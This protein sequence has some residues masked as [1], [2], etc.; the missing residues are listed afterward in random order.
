[1]KEDLNDLIKILERA[2]EALYNEEY[3][4]T[5]TLIYDAECVARFI[6]D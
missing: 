2:Y 1:M 4:D 3:S 6:R 5:K